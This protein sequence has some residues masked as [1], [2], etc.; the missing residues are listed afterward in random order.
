MCYHNAE[1]LTEKA[2][3]NSDIL[4]ERIYDTGDYGR[5]IE[6]GMIEF[7]GRKDQ[8][9]KINGYR[10]EIGEIYSAF[11]KAGFVNEI[12]VIPADDVDGGRM[13][14]AFIK[15]DGGDPD[16]NIQIIRKKLGKFLPDY[17]IPETFIYIDSFPLTANGKTDRKKLTALIGKRP[18][19][20]TDEIP[21]SDE[22][23]LSGIIRSV[24]GNRNINYND[25]FD[26]AG[27]S[28]MEI[29]R[30]ANRLEKTFGSRP[31]VYE[32]MNGYSIKK[33]ADFYDGNAPR[34][35]NDNGISAEYSAERNTA[36]DMILKLYAKGVALYTE[37]GKLK[38]RSRNPVCPDDMDL[39]RKNKTEIIECLENGFVPENETFPLQTFRR[40]ILPDVRPILNLVAFRRII[41]LNC[42]TTANLT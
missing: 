21:V 41:I 40:H 34:S 16:E 39:L 11:R 13:L 31:P 26:S 1:E 4:H 8:Q 35:V 15:R 14:A 6:G 2:F 38:F 20:N 19:I 5:Y 10:I 12:Q 32:M 29:I 9:V 18:E 27:V 28:S 23:G 33:L 36:E 22:S 30:L 7:L 25:R 3:I 24:F 42:N 17:F 37:N